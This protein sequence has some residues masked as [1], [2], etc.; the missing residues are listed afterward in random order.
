MAL[1]FKMNQS[2]TLPAGFRSVV[3]ERRATGFRTDLKE[4]LGMPGLKK[5]LATTKVRGLQTML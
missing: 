3:F 5:I 2:A 1:T 4:H